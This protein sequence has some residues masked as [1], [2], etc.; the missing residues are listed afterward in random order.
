[1]T[2]T[3]KEIEIEIINKKYIITVTS[4]CGLRKA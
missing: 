1:M 2:G 3:L 4:L